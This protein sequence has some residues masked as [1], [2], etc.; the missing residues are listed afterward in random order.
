[1]DLALRSYEFWLW[2][3]RRVW[4]GSFA[5]SLVNPVFYLAAL[6]VGLG[7]LVNH[8]TTRPGHVSYIDFVAPG[9]LVAAAMQTAAAEA[10]FPVLAALKW[11]RQYH[12][13]LATP[14]GIRD[15]L[16]GHQLFVLTRVA[17]SGGIYVAV[18][19]AFGAIRSPWG[20]L[21]WPAAVLTGGAFASPIAAYSAGVAYR[22]GA[23]FNP[24]FRFVI[25]PMFLFSG[26]FFP[27]SRLPV[28]LDWVAYA[29]PLW[30]GVALSRDLTLG[31][32]HTLAD[33][34][35]AAY[36]VVWF[37]SGV[38]IALRAYRTRLVT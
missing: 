7:S 35:H 4:R 8:S 34:G 29:T 16:F 5:T 13:Q 31:R 12:A 38:A 26:T 19:A 32:V 2:R 1:M 21:A 18:V 22:S 14:L 15:V 17:M 25:I 6:G 9:L 23:E 24:L 28:P 20:V 27:V 3:Y 36:L 33:C 11:V 10:S 30:H 37:V